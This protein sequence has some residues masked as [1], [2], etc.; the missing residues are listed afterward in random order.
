MEE[1]SNRQMTPDLNKY[2]ASRVA[3]EA[4]QLQYPVPP[5]TDVFRTGQPALVKRLDRPN[6]YLLVPIHNDAG[7]CGIVQLEAQSLSLETVSII[8]D[9]SSM[10]LAT[11]DAVLVAVQTAF[12]KRSGW[13]KPFLAWQP[14]RESFDSTRP[15]W[16]VPYSN[17]QIFVNQ[18]CQV[19]ETLTAGQGG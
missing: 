8:K 17:G 19:F 11:E 5:S 16:V 1:E 2:D 10:F 15:F 12:P 13:Q 14:C 7:L 3:L 9:P 6:A 18:G 4:F